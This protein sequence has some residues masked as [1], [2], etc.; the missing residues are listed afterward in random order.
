[1]L[2]ARLLLGSALSQIGWLI[3]GFSSVFF[4]AFVWNADLSGWKFRPGETARVTGVA[5]DCRQTRLSEGGSRNRRGTPIYETRYRY[6]VDG[7]PFAGSSFATGYC[8]DGNVRVE[9]LEA[10]PEI[11]RIVGTRRKPFGPYVVTVGVLPAIGLTLILAGIVSGLRQRRLLR[12][13]LPAAARLKEK[14]PLNMTSQGRTV[15]RLIF[16]F[17]AQNGGNGRVTA[18]S[19]R[20][21]RLEKNKDLTILSWYPLCPDRLPLTKRASRSRAK[22][23]CS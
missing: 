9:Y 1:M 8:Y 13:G 15:Y 4:W 14:V 19:S 5:L 3:V 21:E 20:Y 11:S 10:R 23:P 6:E 16:E 7:H 2:A 22:Q 17:T 18:R 12:D